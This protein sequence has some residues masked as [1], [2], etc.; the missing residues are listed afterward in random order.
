MNPD[1]KR[2]DR[3]TVFDSPRFAATGFPARMPQLRFPRRAGNS[4]APCAPILPHR[5]MTAILL[6][7]LLLGLAGGTARAVDMDVLIGYGQNTSSGARYR[8]ETWT[9]LTV[10]L[11]GQG[12]HGDAQL[13]VSVRVAEHTTI[14]TR[15]VSLKDGP[16]NE[17]V[18]FTVQLRNPDY[19]NNFNSGGYPTDIEVQLIMDGRTLAGPKKLA[20][21]GAVS[22][23]TYNVLGL[24]RDGSGLNLLN[25]KK[26]GLFHRHFNPSRLAYMGMNNMNGNEP[27]FRNG[28]NPNATLQVLYTDARALPV[29]PQGYEAIDAIVLGDL[30][31]DNL[32]EDQLDAIRGYVR[33]GGLLIISGG[34]DLA[35]L[36]SAFYQE[37][38]PAT[39]AG[40]TVT[41]ELNALERRYRTP[42]RL[43]GGAAITMCARPL[44]PGATRLLDNTSGLD[45]LGAMN[46]PLIVSRPYGSGVVVFTA[47]DLLDP[48]IKGWDGAPA[49]WRDLLRCGNETVSGRDVLAAAAENNQSTLRIGD[50]L[51]G[52]RATSAPPLSLV[53]L[54]CGAYLILLVPVNYFVLKRLDRREMTWVTAPLLIAG[55]TLASYLVA[56]S[57]KGGDLTVNRALVIETQANSDQAAGYA[58]MTVYSPRRST[59]DI[60]FGN[61]DDP[62]SPYHGLIPGEIFTNP[63]QS[64]GADLTIDSDQN[65][66]VL[67]NTL[68]KLWD[69]RSFDMPVPVNL[70][71]SVDA[72]TRATSERDLVEVQVT[73]HTRFTLADC[74]LIGEGNAALGTLAPGETKTAK[75]RWNTRNT[76]FN[77]SLP[78]PTNLVDSASSGDE[79]R[80]DTPAMTQTRIASALLQTLSTGTEQNQ[81]GYAPPHGYG[82][83][84]NALIG[85]FTDPL[86]DVRVDGRQPDGQEVNLL[87]VDLPLPQ[88]APD[89]VRAKIDPFAAIPVLDLEDETPPGTR[90]GVLR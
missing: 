17:A 9:P 8:P 63:A 18:N 26:L 51:A 85:R 69:K 15:R 35:R 33:D 5:L 40:A 59:Y 58:Q 60:A 62:N 48:N 21:P 76:A 52:R 66:A 46:Y 54:F 37:M 75:F 43:G 70:G 65:G 24:T 39:P 61:H 71:G 79:K 80:D 88:D 74:A 83:G 36:K 67:R 77:L 89:A 50:A 22:M 56:R 73:N 12:T 87:V 4:P 78:V 84:A 20:L 42:L 27:T 53:G 10:Y 14:Y 82:R 2:P 45:K 57:L 68:I 29:Q 31:L 16:L 38:L 6:T 1:Q 11:T 44:K 49:L 81:Y 25:K 32:S 90:M 47:F 7:L 28:I 72:V 86:V 13:Q 19:N 55:F 3:L 41:P 23:E 34:G 64:L 30:P